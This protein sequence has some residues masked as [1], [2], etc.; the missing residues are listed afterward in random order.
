MAVIPRLQTSA[1]ASYAD[2]LI[3]W[4]IKMFRNIVKRSI[5][6]GWRRREKLH[7][8]LVVVS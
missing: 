1:L 3:T 4:V 7:Q 8:V 2:C 5:L 6:R